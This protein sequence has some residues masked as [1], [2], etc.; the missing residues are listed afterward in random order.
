MNV[1]ESLYK[2]IQGLSAEELYMES[3]GRF[4]NQHSKKAIDDL[5][6]FLN[7]VYYRGGSQS[8]QHSTLI[9]ATT[10][11]L[12]EQFDKTLQSY[13]FGT[14]L[15]NSDK[16]AMAAIELKNRQSFSHTGYTYQATVENKKKQAENA[17]LAITGN[18]SEEIIK[19][20]K[21]IEEFI[22]LCDDLLSNGIPTE[23]SDKRTV[24]KVADNKNLIEKIDELYKEITF[25]NDMPLSVY[26]TG[27]VFEKSLEALNLSNFAD[28]Q[29][30]EILAV[31]NEK[32]TGQ[33]TVSRGGL[34]SNAISY[35]YTDDGKLVSNDESLSLSFK[36]N[37]GSSYNIN[38]V[39][40]NKQGKMD[41]E[42]ILPNISKDSFRVSAKNWKD[43][44][45]DFGS[46]YLLHAILRS[47][48]SLDKALAYG[49]SYK[50]MSKQPIKVHYFA[51]MCIALDILA[52]YSQKEG[53][54]DTIIINNRQNG[55]EILVYSIPT[56]LENI[57]NNISS[58]QISG[59]N[60]SNIKSSLNPAFGR[61]RISLDGVVQGLSGIA[62]T[63]KYSNL[64][65]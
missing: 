47:S 56:L 31:F 43:L 54:A 46:T 10:T 30:N 22:K 26:D 38:S 34:L 55:G 62:V 11:Y 52:G 14:N 17:L 9:N 32:T 57:Y 7:D 19:A 20:K 29:I 49:I 24:F 53:Y 25:F 39:F 35:K 45:G 41:V 3:K 58:F 44:N 18:H 15:I 51:K 5:N 2:V 64:I 33:Q 28:R 48:S 4:K 50:N 21:T 59:Y 63:L 23:L 6:N 42:L 40:S 8:K 27:Y 13:D 60:I 16:S 37:N 1:I 12:E 61:S 36:G 65:L